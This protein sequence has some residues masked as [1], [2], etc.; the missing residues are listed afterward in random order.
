MGDEERTIAGVAIQPRDDPTECYEY[1]TSYTV[2]YANIHGREDDTWHDI[3]GT[4]TGN[5][6]E[7]GRGTEKG[8]FDNP[9]SA[10]WVKIIPKTAVNWISMRAEVLLDLQT[11][12][13]T[14]DENPTCNFINVP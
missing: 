9:I 7:T 5:N 8:V 3:P 1:V 12:L 6:T 11:E 10:R 13:G 2:K 4:F 14:E